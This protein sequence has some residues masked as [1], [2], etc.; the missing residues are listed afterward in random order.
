MYT[1]CDLNF[2]N[3]IQA[4]ILFI[5]KFNNIYIKFLAAMDQSSEKYFMGK[6]Y[7]ENYICDTANNST[8]WLATT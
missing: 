5:A 3:N 2:G 8:V 6:S 4:I 1:S 7:L